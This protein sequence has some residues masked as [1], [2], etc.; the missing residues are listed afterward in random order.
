M[1]L[2]HRRS[3]RRLLVN[4]LL[5]FARI[6]RRRA[7]RLVLSLGLVTG[8]VSVGIVPPAGALTAACS[9]GWAV[10]SS[11]NVGPYTNELHGVTAISATNAWA[12][13]IASSN[14]L[15]EHWNGTAWSVS[16]SP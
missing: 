13:G 14:T 8:S 12:V 10:V 11:P 6:L 7:P 4:V 2:A 5:A 3:S 15:I 9:N 1:L 16:S